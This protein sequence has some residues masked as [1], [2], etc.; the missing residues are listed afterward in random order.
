M[1][2]EKN[3][4]PSMTPFPR[5]LKVL[6]DGCNLVANNAKLLILPLV[7]D[8]ILL[9]GPRL[10][11]AAYFKPMFESAYSQMIASVSNTA[12]AQLELA[13]E[14]ILDFLDKINLSGMIQIFP[15]G[16]NLLDASG[17]AVTPLGTAASFEMRS[18]FQIIPV[19]IVMTVLGVLIGTLYFSVTAGTAGRDGKFMIGNFG[20][21]LLNTV[22][23]Y[24]ALIILLAVLFVPVSCVM[25]FSFMAVPFLYQIIM[26]ILIAAGCWL[27][28]PLFYIPHGIFVKHLDL[29][30]AIKESIGLSSW[31]GPVTIRFMLFSI[32]ISM[33]LDLIWAIPEQNSWLILFSIFGHAFVS[34]A[35]LTASFL[36]FTELDQWQAEN[37]EFLAWRKANLRINKLFKKEPEQ[38][39]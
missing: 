16:V 1:V 38:H 5:V 17:S 3:E 14:L 39:D 34:T 4:I 37:Q 10:R 22:L 12:A 25:T 36:L 21:Q 8:L 11:I 26:I 6:G 24:L 7:F 2:M 33:G 30:Q 23:F 13:Q 9:F 28:I 27:I 31:S 35:L 18:I 32:V 15:I 19:M 29:T 20:K